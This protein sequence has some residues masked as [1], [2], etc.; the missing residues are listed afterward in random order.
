MR[1]LVL[2]ATLMFTTQ[3]YAQTVKS[4][5]SGY[6][7]LS[8][9]YH[10]ITY[11]KFTA[12]RDPY[13]PD[14]DDWRDRAST[15]FRI[16]ILHTLYWDNYVHTESV[17]T[18]TV[19]TVGWHWVAGLRLN[20]YMDIFQEH[21]SRHVMEEDRPTKNG[22]QVFPVEDSY[23]IKFKFVDDPYKKSVGDWLFK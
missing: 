8:L 21:H 16:A 3:A 12:N 10:D 6:R 7:L 13:V 14:R 20:K 19:K 9:E 4:K 11:N 5:H 1:A 2:L 18:G 23:G 17:K 22:K 15:N